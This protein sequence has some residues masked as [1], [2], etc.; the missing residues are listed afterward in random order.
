M[1]S[2]A[3]LDCQGPGS[4]VRL[5]KRLNDSSLTTPHCDLQPGTALGNQQQLPC[6]SQ[7]CISNLKM[8][9]F[10][11]TSSF[12]MVEILHNYGNFDFNLNERI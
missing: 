4:A 3:D 11:L 12:K 2:Q 9:K 1:T 8:G 7:I 6:V 10:P 5:P